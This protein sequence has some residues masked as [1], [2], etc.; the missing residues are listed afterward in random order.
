M[1]EVNSKWKGKYNNYISLSPV[2]MQDS[3]TDVVKTGGH[4]LQ[5]HPPKEQQ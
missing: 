3:G 2:N 4:D 1:V 5:L